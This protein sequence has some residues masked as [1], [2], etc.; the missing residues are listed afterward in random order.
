M[1]NRPRIEDVSPIRYDDIPASY[2]GLPQ[3]IPIPF[4]LDFLPKSVTKQ[5]FL[6]WLWPITWSHLPSC[7]HVFGLGSAGHDV[8]A[9][10]G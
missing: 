5:F 4:H 10:S 1:E 9:L 2:V 7:A 6:G 8:A 3:G